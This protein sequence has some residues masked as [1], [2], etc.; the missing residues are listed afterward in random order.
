M[1]GPSVQEALAAGDLPG[2]IAGQKAAIRQQPTV[3]ELRFLLFQ[4]L[5][6]AGDW[7]GAT[8][9]LAAQRKLLNAESPFLTLLEGLVRA[10]VT[11]EQVFRGEAPPRILGEPPAW[12]ASLA[13]A[14]E[15]SAKGRHEEAEALRGA[16]LEAAPGV[17]GVLNDLAFAWLMD[18]DSRLG[19]LLEIVLN[20]SYFWVPQSRVR[21]LAIE[22]PEQ[23]RDLVWAVA[24]ITLET[25]AALPA[26]L[27]ARYPHAAQWPD[28]ALRL[29]RRTDWQSSVK[30][31]FE[32]QGQRVW[33]TDA[34]E[35]SFLEARSLQFNLAAA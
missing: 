20:G 16:A 30:E 15:L 28:D 11:R 21:S 24:Q 18:G 29:A 6:L 33:M 31:C 32:G 25:G 12:V 13:R 26:F 7:A 23:P 19:P 14:L 8:N 17:S 34:A 2:A 1:A 3:P 22:P 4:L 35:T 5:S 9:Q 10:E 27:P